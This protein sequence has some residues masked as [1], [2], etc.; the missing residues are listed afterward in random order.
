PGLIV[1]GVRH[2]SGRLGGGRA[3]PIG[4]LRGIAHVVLVVRGGRSRGLV[5]GRRGGP[6][7]LR[8]QR[9]GVSGAL[10]G[11]RGDHLGPLGAVFGQPCGQ[12][13]IGAGGSGGGLEQID[14]RG[15]VGAGGQ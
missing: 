9:L 7:D 12:R 15:R 5:T 4:E 1:G 6:L 2:E 10:L 11:D 14:R 8:G 13:R 3:Q